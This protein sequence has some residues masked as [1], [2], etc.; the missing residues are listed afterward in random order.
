MRRVDRWY[1][2]TAL[3]LAPNH[4][5]MRRVSIKYGSTEFVHR[6]RVKLLQHKSIGSGQRKHVVSV[7][8]RRQKCGSQE[9]H[10]QHAVATVS[11][12][13][14]SRKHRGFQ[15]DP[16]STTFSYRITWPIS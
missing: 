10:P 7:Q 5:M 12:S 11:G 15:T 6:Y 14:P 4:A 9:R 1:R 8:K 16:E 2:S 13:N 3:T